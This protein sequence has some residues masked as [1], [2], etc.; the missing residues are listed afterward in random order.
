[1]NHS[2]NYKD[3]VTGVHTNKIE[4]IWAH[5][6]R[7]FSAG[8]RKKRNMFGYLAKYMLQK[9]L[10]SSDDSSSFVAFMNICQTCPASSGAA[11]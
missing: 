6:K 7:D 4:G 5:V 9:R 10:S 11:E 3:P 1:M 8:G 2:K